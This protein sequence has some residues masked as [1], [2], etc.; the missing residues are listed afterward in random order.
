MVQTISIS[1]KEGHGILATNNVLSRNTQLNYDIVASKYSYGM[2]LQLETFVGIL[3][4]NSLDYY[5]YR[6]VVDRHEKEINS[7][8]YVMCEH[9]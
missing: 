3:Q 9:C 2:Q 8:G 5:F 7:Y 6:S 4:Q 1:E